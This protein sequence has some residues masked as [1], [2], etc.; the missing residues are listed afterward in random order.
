[1]VN[2]APITILHK[3]AKCGKLFKGSKL[4][5]AKPSKLTTPVCYILV[6][7]F[8]KNVSNKAFINL[9]KFSFLI[10]L[11]FKKHFLNTKDHI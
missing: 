3:T 1:M 11:I 5:A 7:D 8:F 10:Y 4:I 2:G 9:V 6:F